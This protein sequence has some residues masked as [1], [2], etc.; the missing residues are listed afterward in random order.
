MGSEF[1]K[2][3]NALSPVT[4]GNSDLNSERTTTRAD[5]LSYLT[6]GR[7]NGPAGPVF[8]AVPVWSVARQFRTGYNT[9]E[10]PILRLAFRRGSNRVSR[11]MAIFNGWDS[12]SRLLR[13]E[14][15]RSWGTGLDGSRQ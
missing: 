10:V 5:G 4:T 2:R 11:G 8:S 6:A 1:A 7:R 14:R 3:D 12:G 13:R 15:S 9:P